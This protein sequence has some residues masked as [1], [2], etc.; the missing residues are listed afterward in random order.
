MAKSRNTLADRYGGEVSTALKV[1]I[2]RKDDARQKVRTNT[3]HLVHFVF[4]DLLG[5]FFH[6]FPLFSCVAP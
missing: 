5:L 4:R 6:L 2:K 1:E 3:L